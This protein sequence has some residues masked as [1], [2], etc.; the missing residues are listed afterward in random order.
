MTREVYFVNSKA[1]KFYTNTRTIT[2]D[3]EGNPVSYYPNTSTSICLINR[4]TIDTYYPDIPRQISKDIVNL[5]SIGDGLATISFTHI[6]IRF[7]I[8]DREIIEFTAEVYIVD[9]L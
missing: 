5:S 8:I 3:P 6:P 4:Y 2:Y 1:H 9:E 7:L